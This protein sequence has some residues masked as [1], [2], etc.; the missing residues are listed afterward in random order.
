MRASRP[1]VGPHRIPGD[2]NW[3]QLTSGYSWSI[4]F[5]HLVIVERVHLVVADESTDGEACEARNVVN[6]TWSGAG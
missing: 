3:G 1:V 6:P 4:H 5:T 2:T